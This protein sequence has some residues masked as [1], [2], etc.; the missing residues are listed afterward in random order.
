M[1]NMR[2]DA[3]IGGNSG[4]PTPPTWSRVLARRGG[5]D[6]GDRLTRA[7]DRNRPK[8]GKLRDVPSLAWPTKGMGQEG[9]WS[10]S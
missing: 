8:T 2:Q 6:H 1:A 4:V 9:R 3:G 5:S 7:R 10:V